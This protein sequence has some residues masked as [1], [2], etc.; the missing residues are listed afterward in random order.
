MLLIILIC[1]AADSEAR[2]YNI[3]HN[4]TNCHGYT[5]I[6]PL[7]SLEMYYFFLKDTTIFTKMHKC[8]LVKS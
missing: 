1:N 2:K 6:M 4:L 7:G 5:G 8:D 3:N